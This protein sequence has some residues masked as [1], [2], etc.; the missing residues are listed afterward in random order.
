MVRNRVGSSHEIWQSVGRGG[1]WW[2][3]TND[4]AFVW[5]DPR[6]QC[7]RIDP[8]VMSGLEFACGVARDQTA[9]PLREFIDALLADATSLE[10]ME[11]S[12]V[13]E[14]DQA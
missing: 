13:F 7:P 1:R 11:T 2:W 3:I 6:K 8:E 14:S 10:L 12:L 9:G 4:S 5:E